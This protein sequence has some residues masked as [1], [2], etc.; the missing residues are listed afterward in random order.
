MIWAQHGKLI[1]LCRWKDHILHQEISMRRYNI[2]PFLALGLV[3]IL[4][5]QANALVISTD[6]NIYGSTYMDTRTIIGTFDISQQLSGYTAPYDVNSAYVTFTFSDDNDLEYWG[7]YL[8]NYQYT[9]Y[10]VENGSSYTGYTRNLYYYYQDQCEKVTLSMADQSTYDYTD[11][12]SVRTFENRA[13]DR[14]ESI[15][16]YMFNYY[17][18]EYYTD[19]F[20]YR[21][22]ITLVLSLGDLALA[23]LAD[24]GMIRYILEVDGDLFFE[25]GVLTTDINTSPVPEPA[26]L[27]LFGSGLLGLAGFRKKIQD[28]SC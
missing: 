16:P 12:Y 15:T 24:D 1:A 18:T 20:G 14:T 10:Y 21:G 17:Y 7:S 25:S 4:I 26:T 2:I 27:L 13:L 11:Y 9:D 19:Q 23:D 6:D 8:S 5:T 3:L 22:E 28:S